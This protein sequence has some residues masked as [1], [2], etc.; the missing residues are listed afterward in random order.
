VGLDGVRPR[1]WDVGDAAVRGN[2]NEKHEL[3]QDRLCRRSWKNPIAPNA[4]DY[5]T[6]PK[7]P[8]QRC[9]N[10]TAKDPL[11]PHLANYRSV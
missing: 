4:P 9:R 8:D 6:K 5:L 1:V 3:G 7:Y 2:L 11:F 10:T